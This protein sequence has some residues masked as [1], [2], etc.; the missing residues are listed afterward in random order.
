M[1]RSSVK[2]KMKRS[3]KLVTRK[4]RDVLSGSRSMRDG[5]KVTSMLVER[6]ICKLYDLWTKGG[7]NKNLVPWW[8]CKLTMR[9]H[10]DMEDY[11]K[12]DPRGYKMK[13]KVNVHLDDAYELP[14]ETK[15]SETW[16]FN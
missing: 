9:S 10:V 1:G 13:D 5:K 16:N 11:L 8:F 7:L 6:G 15:R 4:F 2:S 14:D 12:L 3:H